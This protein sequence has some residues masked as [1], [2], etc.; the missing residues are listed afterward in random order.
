M[1]SLAHEGNPKETDDLVITGGS[2]LS[3][4]QL[5]IDFSFFGSDGQEL[6]PDVAE[7]SERSH[8]S[9]CS[10]VFTWA[11]NVEPMT[12]SASP[13]NSSTGDIVRS[14]DTASVIGIKQSPNCYGIMSHNF[15]GVAVPELMSFSSTFIGLDSGAPACGTCLI[16]HEADS[17][18]DVTCLAIIVD[19]GTGITY[20][21][22]FD[23]QDI[24]DVNNGT[25][26]YQA[27]YTPSVGDY[28]YMASTQDSFENTVTAKIYSQN[29]FAGTV[30]WG[31]DMTLTIANLNRAGFIAVGHLTS[32]KAFFGRSANQACYGSVT[33]FTYNEASTA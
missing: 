25:I 23:G 22:Q 31:T 7:P 11:P 24:R 10:E 8:A 12:W 6:V 30:R 20:F 26:L 4:A 9:T 3:T 28:F 18:E 17:T 2:V 14:F 1:P 32:G 33:M 29:Q 13:C 5:D 21:V 27:T 19:W 16:A 15:P